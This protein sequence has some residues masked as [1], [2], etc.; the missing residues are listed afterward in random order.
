[1]FITKRDLIRSNEVLTDYFERQL[2]KTFEVNNDY[3]DGKIKKLENE[4][5][6]LKKQILELKSQLSVLL[7]RVE[8]TEKKK[9]FEEDRQDTIL[10]DIKA[11][12]EFSLKDVLEHY[13]IQ[14]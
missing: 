7:L 2:D 8:D 12:Q 4:N 6:D 13:G 10:K 3:Y 9:I 5:K 11:I 14:G 1:M